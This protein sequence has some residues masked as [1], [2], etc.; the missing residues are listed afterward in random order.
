[1]HTHNE[2]KKMKTWL[3]FYIEN[4]VR[5]KNIF[6]KEPGWSLGLHSNFII[7]SDTRS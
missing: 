5:E 4:T 7:L 6:R 1:M 3:Y 2:N